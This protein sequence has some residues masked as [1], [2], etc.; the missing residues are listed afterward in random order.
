MGKVAEAIR[1]KLTAALEPTHLDIE[2]DSHRH[3]GHAGARPGGESHFNVAIESAAFAGLR[4]VERQRLVHRV[5]AEELA[6]PVHA[7]SL[8]LGTPS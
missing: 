5:L 7:L 3:A 8:K 4:P 1:A 6:G 2:D